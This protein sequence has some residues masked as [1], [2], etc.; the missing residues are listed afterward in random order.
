MKT[1]ADIINLTKKTFKNKKVIVGLSIFLIV[2]LTLIISL[3]CNVPQNIPEE[4]VEQEPEKAHGYDFDELRK[5]YPEII[6]WL[7]V[8]NTAIDT[9]ICCNDKDDAYYL[10][11]DASQNYDI[12]G[13]AYIEAINSKDFSDQITVVYGHTMHGDIAFTPLHKF[14]DQAFFDANTEFYI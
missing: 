9:P 3:Y 6:A 1:K 5:L 8:P 12:N 10:K 2:I 14:E 7:I 4:D 11:H 13:V